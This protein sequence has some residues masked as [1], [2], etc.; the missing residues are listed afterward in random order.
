MMEWAVYNVH[1]HAVAKFML[2][3]DAEYYV[4]SICEKYDLSLNYYTI[5]Q[6]SDS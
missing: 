5:K 3:L 4:K 6:E 1:N 2:K